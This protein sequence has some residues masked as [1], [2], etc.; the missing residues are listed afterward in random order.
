LS[1]LPPAGVTRAASPVD[2]AALILQLAS[3]GAMIGSLVAI[4]SAQNE[5]VAGGASAGALVGW[6]ASRARSRAG[7]FGWT[8]LMSAA[9]GAMLLAPLAR[10][11][12]DPVLYVSGA[13]IGVFVAMPLFLLSLP[14]FRARRRAARARDRSILRTADGAATWTGSCVAT[15]LLGLAGQPKIVIYDRLV[16]LSVVFVALG[17]VASL[18]VVFLDLRAWTAL[19]RLARSQAA[20]G[21]SGPS[22]PRDAGLG[23]DVFEERVPASNPFRSA[24]KVTEVIVGSVPIAQRALWRSLVG[25]AVSFV[26]CAAALFLKTGL[27]GR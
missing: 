14:A 9:G 6:A 5:F 24:D 22:A 26:V 20:T 2:T 16:D 17:T 8:L 3:V 1:N 15:A 13:S 19:R 18:A 21:E 23:A 12:H 4:Q 7:L 25:D 11:F 10:S 27:V